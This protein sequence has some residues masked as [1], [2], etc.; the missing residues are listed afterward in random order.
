M[1]NIGRLNPDL[2]GISR[3]LWAILLLLC[4]FLIWNR[5]SDTNKWLK[6]GLRAA[7]LTGLLVIAILFRSGTFDNPGWMKTGW[8]GILGLIGWG[9]VSGAVTY[10]IVRDNLLITGLVTLFFLAVNSLSQLKLLEFM[11]FVKPVF[12][13]IKEGNI[14]FIVLS[15]VF[16]S[17]VLKNI[18]L[19]SGRKPAIIFITGVLVFGCGFIFR[20]WFIISKIKGTPSWG[21]IC[22]GISMMLF[23][24]IY[25]FSDILKNP[26]RLKLFGIAGRN[27]LTVYLAP[28]VLYYLIWMLNLPVFVYKQKEFQLVAVAGSLLWAFA[29]LWVGR[30]LSRAGVQLK[31]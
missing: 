29:M 6:I 1:Y 31:L 9:Y 8:W 2:S 4:V 22:T 24:V 17:L 26:V 3:N 7:G 15:G 19:R 20:N 13:V 16:T 14:P 25:L 12:G 21:L 18:A 23:S 30:L 27:S 10:M 28:D 11:N 5:Y